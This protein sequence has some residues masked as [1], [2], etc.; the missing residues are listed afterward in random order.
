MTPEN[1]RV[2]IQQALEGIL[3]A[4]PGVLTDDINLVE[5]ELL[6]SLDIMEFLASVEEKVGQKFVKDDEIDFE[7]F[8]MGTLISKISAVAA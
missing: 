2:I 7:L 8:E 4:D 6:D 3:G 1:A 5:L